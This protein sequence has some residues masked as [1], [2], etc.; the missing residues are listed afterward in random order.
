MTHDD[1]EPEFVSRLRNEWES[2][3]PALQAAS[4]GKTAGLNL[5]VTNA[6]TIARHLREELGAV[7]PGAEMSLLII[8]CASAYQVAIEPPPS[9]DICEIL[10]TAAIRVMDLEDAMAVAAAEL[11]IRRAEDDPGE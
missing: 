7:D 10:A 9:R 1:G 11:E 4:E 8:L 3:P 5:L 2:F 6:V